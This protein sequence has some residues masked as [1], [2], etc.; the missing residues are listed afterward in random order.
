MAAPN[1][2]TSVKDS[3]SENP[4]PKATTGIRYVTDDENIGED[5]WISL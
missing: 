3:L 1:P 2:W 4:Q 5:I